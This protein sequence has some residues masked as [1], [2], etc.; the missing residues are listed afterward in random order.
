MNIINLIKK[1]KKF[2]F[3]GVSTEYVPGISTY[4]P[5]Q[6]TPRVQPF[7]P[8]SRYFQVQGIKAP[9][10]PSLDKESLKGLAGKGHTNDVNAI[11]GRAEQAEALL[12][13]KMSADPYYLKTNEGKALLQQ[14]SLS[15]TDINKMLQYKENTNKAE[16]LMMKNEG[17]SS[18]ATTSDGNFLVKGDKGIQIVKPQDYFSNKERYQLL[19]NTQIREM[20][21]R[22]PNMTLS[23]ISPYITNTVGQ[24]KVDDYM[25]NQFINLGHSSNAGERE[26]IGNLQK[27]GSPEELLG[28]IKSSGSNNNN[29]QQLDMALKAMVSGMP[30]YIRN[31]LYSQ[32]AQQANTPQE[33]QEKMYSFLWNYANKMRVNESKSSQTIQ[34]NEFMNKASGMGTDKTKLVDN[35]DFFMKWMGD[36]GLAPV[37]EVNIGNG[38]FN[39]KSG[40]SYYNTTEWVKGDKPAT[41]TSDRH[42]I[43]G[44]RSQLKDK[45]LRTADGKPIPENLVESMIMSGDKKAVIIHA[46]PTDENRNPLPL[47]VVQR[48]EKENPGKLQQ[49]INSGRVTSVT[50]FEAAMRV[51]RSAG[52]FGQSDT[53]EQIPGFKYYDMDDTGK[54]KQLRDEIDLAR[55]SSNVGVNAEGDYTSPFTGGWIT[56]DDDIAE[57]VVMMVTPKPTYTIN[58]MKMNHPDGIREAQAQEISEQWNRS[59]STRTDERVY[60][61][62]LS[63]QGAG[64]K[65]APNLGNMFNFLQK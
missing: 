8:D 9:E 51:P 20:R 43:Q 15:Q 49:I 63:G 13:Q 26:M 12:K 17:G 30:S 42:L 48:L 41:I 45:T 19:T 62:A 54:G 2:Q 50:L 61:T 29:A 16:D 39:I 36:K 7:I 37:Q 32:A 34:A 59:S 1:I 23:D 56:A 31:T 58:G 21:D 35:G 33:A 57:G 44:I 4:I 5:T 6:L 47:E 52:D 24:G 18:F 27:F 14:M 28:F 40:G 38:Q 11:V 60:N 3:G 22:D 10:T 64:S 55:K 46:Y 65:Q 25:K 53:Q